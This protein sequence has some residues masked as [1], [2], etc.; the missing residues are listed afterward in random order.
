[1]L[2]KEDLIWLPQTE[3]KDKRDLK[4]LPAEW[5]RNQDIQLQTLK[6]YS[7]V[8]LK[9]HSNAPVLTKNSQ[10]QLV[11]Y[12][13]MNKDVSKPVN[14]FDPLSELETSDNPDQIAYNQV[15]PNISTSKNDTSLFDEDDDSSIQLVTQITV[16]PEEAMI[17]LID[18][19]GS[20]EK[21]YYKSE[22]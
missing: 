6:I 16:E 9:M 19:S 17:V 21:E 5:H 13:S 2:E 7:S 8:Q 14:L 20:M 18:V 3:F 4:S 1:M 12:T 15:L 22:F 10:N 11:I